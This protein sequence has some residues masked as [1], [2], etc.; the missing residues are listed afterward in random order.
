MT[1]TLM[2]LASGLFLMSCAVAPRPSIAASNTNIMIMGDDA[3]RDTLSRHSRVFERVLDALSNKLSDAGF[4]V[5]DEAAVTLGGF[6]QGRSGRTDAEVIDIARSVRRPPIDVGVIFSIYASTDEWNY[7]T[8]VKIRIAGR[9]LNVKSGQRLGNFEVIAPKELNA[10]VECNRECIQ[11]VAGDSA[12]VL[13]R[14]LG[15]VLVDKLEAMVGGGGTLAKGRTVAKGET[16]TGRCLPNAFTLVFDDFTTQEMMDAEEYLVVFSGYKS[17]RPSYTSNT[18]HEYWYESCIES[19]RLNRNLNRM[20]EHLGIN[21]RV[22]FSGNL[23]TVQ[24]ITVRAERKG[25]RQLDPKDW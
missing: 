3:D 15:A 7:T 25:R 18:R 21:S 12:R 23:F 22:T 17:H 19:G 1:R 20:A 2:I 9:L 14:D 5:Y 8:K 4:N 11:E 10:P 13:A 24:K 16:T 6:T